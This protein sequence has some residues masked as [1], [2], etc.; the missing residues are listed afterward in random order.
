MINQYMRILISSISLGMFCIAF[1]C[2]SIAQVPNAN[3]KSPSHKSVKK[4]KPHKCTKHK[5]QSSSKPIMKKNSVSTKTSV[6]PNTDTKKDD[7]QSKTTESGVPN[8]SN[9]SSKK[10][11]ANDKP[12]VSEAKGAGAFIGDLRDLPKTKPVQQE[13]PK[14]GEPK[15]KPKVYKDPTIKPDQEK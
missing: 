10:P 3:N 11:V 8:K 4:T 7:C 5:K 6:S 9:Q 15:T 12:C 13:Q 2:S 1:V 14:P